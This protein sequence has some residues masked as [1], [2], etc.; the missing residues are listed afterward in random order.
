MMKATVKIAHFKKIKKKSNED[1]KFT[2]ATFVAHHYDIKRKIN[3]QKIDIL[4]L[5]ILWYQILLG[6]NVSN[7]KKIK[8]ILDELK[9]E[10]NNAISLSDF[11]LE[12]SMNVISF[13]R[14]SVDKLKNILVWRKNIYD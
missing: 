7:S 4:D 8:E 10:N 5:D 13:K 14:F 6:K 3:Y 9:S 2:K 11:F 1:L 12:N